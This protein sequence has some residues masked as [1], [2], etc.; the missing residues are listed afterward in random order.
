MTEL[1]NQAH[2]MP[3][4]GIRCRRTLPVD[5]RP[6]QTAKVTRQVPV[7]SL[8]YDLKNPDPVRR[9]EAAKLLGDNKVQTAIPDLVTAASDSDAAVRR[10]IVIALDKMRDMRSLP[11]FHLLS[12]DREKDIRI[13]ASSA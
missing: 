1:L 3:Q 9:K 11:A 2:P 5:D 6:C 7:E 10:E 13:A 12:A 8:I 4:V